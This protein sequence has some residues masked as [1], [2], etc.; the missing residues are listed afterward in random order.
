MKDV[1][2]K[3][4]YGIGMS[5]RQNMPE[6]LLETK[7]GDKK[8]SCDRQPFFYTYKLVLIVRTTKISQMIVI[9]RIHGMNDN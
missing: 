4:A 1:I 7:S 5:R 9:K 2:K 6:G 3:I 8:P